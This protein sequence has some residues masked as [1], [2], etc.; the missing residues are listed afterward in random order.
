MIVT[1]YKYDLGVQWKHELNVSPLG[2]LLYSSC[3]A[4]PREMR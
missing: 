4:K 2:A 1:N 3:G